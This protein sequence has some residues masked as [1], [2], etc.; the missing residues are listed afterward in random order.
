MFRNTPAYNNGTEVI[1]GLRQEVI[2]PDPTDKIVA[3]T[4]PFEGKL[5]VLAYELYGN[6]ELWWVIAELNQ[7]VDP[8]T[9]I[10]LGLQL[11]VPTKERLNNILST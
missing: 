4:Q 11:R 9:E 5:D 8:L 2:V 3:V 6:T 10:K 1:F 7:I